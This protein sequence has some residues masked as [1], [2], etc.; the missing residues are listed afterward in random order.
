MTGHVLIADNVSTNR[1]V[2]KV[3]LAA[4]S[5]RVSLAAD[6]S[7]LLD[8]ALSQ[9]PDVVLL[10]GGIDQDRALDLVDELKTNPATQAIPVLILAG[11]F[12]AADR[13]VAL[14]AGAADIVEKPV[15]GHELLARIRNI[16]R[17]RS[18]EHELRLREDTATELG[19]NE[20]GTDF[21]VPA[22]ILMINVDQP[23]SAEWMQSL[24]E[25]AN[26]NFRQTPG[27]EAMEYLAKSQTSPDII[28]FNPGATT[29]MN[30]LF[31]M[32]EL[33]NRPSTR[34]AEI[35]LLHGE[36]WKTDGTVP[37]PLDLGASE[38]AADTIPP[39]E[40]VFRLKR[41][42]RRKQKA[43]KLRGTV[44]R[45]LRM[46]VTD[47][48]TGLFNRRYALPHMT[49]IAE[50]SR[51]TGNTFAVMV[52]DLD[53][54]K[55]INDT[56]GHRTGDTVLCEVAN[57][58]KAN[59]RNIDLIARIGGEEFL[60]VMPE[61]NLASAK[62]AAERLRNVTQVR[63]IKVAGLARGVSVTTSI[64]VSIAGQ[65]GAPLLAME[66]MVERADRALL[67]AKSTGR[68]QVICEKSAA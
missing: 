10:D 17:V 64:G 55:Q 29:K 44:E 61:T 7:E 56:Y 42:L 52:L 57:R 37:S 28:I 11:D 41:L 18:V 65:K 59:V 27:C 34:H 20:P 6:G 49:R 8:L 50:K 12:T 3:K 32:A 48:L 19:F 5:Y 60:V 31:L 1:I 16:Q 66:T 51:V 4:A 24:T 58:L 15:S 53:H 23:A 9:E 26:F 14:M 68:N 43:D 38:V 54:F 2:L 35:L 39:G 25:L 36:D 67:G 40:L 45:G 13:L 46:A 33:R 62:M 47:P 21:D 63:P 22:Q 30:E